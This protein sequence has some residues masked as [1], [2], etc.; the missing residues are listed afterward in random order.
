M[1][2]QPTRIESLLAALYTVGGARFWLTSK[3]AFF[4]QANLDGWVTRRA[5]QERCSRWACQGGLWSHILHLQMLP[6]HL[7]HLPMQQAHAT[8]GRCSQGFKD[9]CPAD[10]L[11]HGW[12]GCARPD[13]PLMF[14]PLQTSEDKT[15][16][17]S[18]NHLRSG[19]NSFWPR[20]EKKSKMEPRPLC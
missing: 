3:S 9:A 20:C 4:V 17:T 5:L 19:H 12:H 13:S 14:C 15:H 11:S 7:L 18:I 10:G 16:R 6:N 8:G 1:P 2:P